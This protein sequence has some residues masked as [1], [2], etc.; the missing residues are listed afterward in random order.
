MAPLQRLW[1]ALEDIPGGEAVL[2]EWH[3]RLASDFESTQSLLR[4]TDQEAGCYPPIAGQILPYRLVKHGVDD[5]AGVPPDG[6]E[7]IYLTRQDV[8]I[9]RIDH[10]RLAKE[11]AATLGFSPF[12]AKLPGS[13]VTWR[14]GS[15]AKAGGT[16]LPVHLVLP[17][18]PSELHRAI[19]AIA[20]LAGDVGVVIAPTRRCFKPASE[21]LLRLANGHFIALGHSLQSRDREKWHV[22]LDTSNLLTAFLNPAGTVADEPLGERSQLALIAM[23]E[24]GALDSDR[25]RSTEDIAAKALGDDA[26]SNSL[27]SVMAELKT[28]ELIESKTGRG[29][30]CW[31]TEKGRARADKL[32]SQ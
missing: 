6:G 32:R 21:T 29:G 27:K 23:F 22:N 24:L 8:L 26:D 4:L 15:V 7:T 25:R 9:Y 31:L 1:P 12:F 17:A 19:E 18:E 16:H 3:F 13:P 10:R 11:I 2:A 28:R 30:G 20:S 5:F 14:I